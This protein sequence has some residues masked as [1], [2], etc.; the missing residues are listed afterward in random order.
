VSRD[1]LLSSTAILT[2]GK[3]DLVVVTERAQRDEHAKLR[4]KVDDGVTHRKFD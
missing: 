2:V 3:S 4:L 1:S